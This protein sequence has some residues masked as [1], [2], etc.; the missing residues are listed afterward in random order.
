MFLVVRLLVLDVALG[1]AMS[2]N[3]TAA[4]VT[5]YRTARHCHSVCCV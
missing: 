4:S 5:Q 2:D 3:V 1:H